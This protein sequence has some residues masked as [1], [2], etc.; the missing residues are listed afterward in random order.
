MFSTPSRRLRRHAPRTV[1]LAILCCAISATLGSPTYGQSAPIVDR[2]I[3]HH[4]GE[5]FRSTKTELNL[6]SK[7]GCFEISALVDGDRYEYDVTQPAKGDRKSR[8]VISSNDRVEFWEDGQL[9]KL[10]SD[11]EQRWRDWA[12][13]RIY[14]CFLPYR[15]RD[16]SVQV[17]DL[18]VE[19]WDGRELHKVKVTFEVGSSTDASDQ[20]LYW[21]D[22][23][24][25]QVEQ[26]AYSYEG[27][28]GGLRFRKGFNYRRESGLLFFDQENW[29]VEGE[30]LGVDQL[31]PD[32]V[33]TLRLVS[34]VAITD[35][36][37][38]PVEASVGTE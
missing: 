20:Y 8:R 12:A 35:L 29:G 25:G 10:S 34:T 6:C 18:G 7:S 24:N 21:F 11:E 36:T 13:A 26:F 9:Q 14:F 28:P 22:P 23:K 33:K 37:V 2:A 3:E 15:L 1:L 5:L 16:P 32:F 27:N 38:T 19:E 30:N 31:T 4:G 17:E